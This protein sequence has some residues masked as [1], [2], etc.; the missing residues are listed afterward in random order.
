[1]SE[2][3][4]IKTTGG[5]LWTQRGNG[6][7]V[8]GACYVRVYDYIR[9]LQVQLTAA[10]CEAA[11]LRE[12]AEEAETHASSLVSAR[13]LTI[14]DLRAEAEEAR[15]KALD[16]V[17]GFV[18]AVEAIRVAETSGNFGYT[19]SQWGAMLAELAHVQHAIADTKPSTTQAQIVAYLRSRWTLPSERGKEACA[20]ADEIEAGLVATQPAATQA[21]ADPEPACPFRLVMSCPSC[22]KLHV[23]RGEWATRLHKTHL[24]VDDP[25]S[26]PEKG[27]G[28]RWRPSEHPTVGVATLQDTVYLPGDA[29][30][31]QAQAGE[32][33]T[34]ARVLADAV[35]EMLSHSLPD[36]CDEGDVEVD[37]TLTVEDVN[38]VHRAMTQVR[39]A[40][41]SRAPAGKR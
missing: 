12:R 8:C 3:E 33:E 2:C 21:Q 5:H 41:A 32:V 29:T 31:A 23:D 38:A 18:D 14:R 17:R 22:G 36:D 20:L 16:M 37:V 34:S 1:M 39:A 13:D 9:G 25:H 24:C 26:A 10:Q 40:L 28:T 11:E 7:V 35:D 19:P 4:H 6:Q 30:Q 27:C 15:G